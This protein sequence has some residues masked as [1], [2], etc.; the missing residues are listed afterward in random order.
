MTFIPGWR[1]WEGAR[2]DLPAPSSTSGLTQVL[3]PGSGLLLLGSAEGGHRRESVR[4]VFNYLAGE[5]LDEAINRAAWDSGGVLTVLK[6]SF[7][8][9][10]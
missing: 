10:S 1:P 9:S 2:R 7:A 8:A 6:D 4:P 5:K 3:Q